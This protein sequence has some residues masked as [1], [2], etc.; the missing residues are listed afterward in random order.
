MTLSRRAVVILAS[1]KTEDPFPELR[2]G[3]DD[4]AGL[5]VE[6]ADQMEQ[7]CAAGFWERDVAQLVD[8]HTV[9]GRELPDDLAGIALGLFLDQGIDQIDSVEEAGLLAIV[10]QGGSERDGNMGFACAGSSHQYVPPTSMRLCASMVNW[11]EQKGS[12]LA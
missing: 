9:Q 4:D 3:G 10:D 2:V 6:L 11:P 7:Q 1:P 8:D 12:I 5:L